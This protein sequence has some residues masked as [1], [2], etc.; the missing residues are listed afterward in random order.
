MSFSDEEK[1]IINDNYNSML[2]NDISKMIHANRSDVIS[3]AYNT[4]L[5]PK[6][7]RMPLVSDF[8]SEYITSRQKSGEAYKHIADAVGITCKQLR[9]WLKNH[10]PD[11]KSRRRKFNTDYFTS[12]NTET[13]AYYL[14]FI[15]A[16]GWIYKNIDLGTYEFAME[17]QDKDSY[18]L[19]ELSKELGGVHAVTHSH[20]SIKIHNNKFVSECDM[21]KIRVYSKD[22]VEDL[23]ANGID[24]NKTKTGVFPVVNDDMFLPFLKGYIDGDGCIHKMSERHLGVHITSATKKVLEYVNDSAN[25]LLGISGKIYS[26]GDRKYRL[27][28]F[29][30][31]DVKTLLDTIYNIKTPELRRKRDVYEDFYGLSSQ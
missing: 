6:G 28:W 7:K 19:D 9:G 12:I 16:D 31:G 26:E 11:M 14:G 30:D 15:Y 13:K 25:R 22:I 2:S 29:R 4:G 21:A 18:I 1:I 3:F 8:D 5:Q 10:M 23:N 17:L 24:F 20:K 27:Y